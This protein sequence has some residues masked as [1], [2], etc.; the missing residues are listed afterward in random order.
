MIMIGFKP[1]DA[2]TH[3]TASRATRR[4]ASSLD[5]QLQNAG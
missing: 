2:E 3:F 4:H 5:A 1:H